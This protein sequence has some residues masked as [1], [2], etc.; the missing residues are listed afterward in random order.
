MKFPNYELD[1]NE[2]IKIAQN[3]KVNELYLFGSILTKDFTSKSDIDILVSFSPES[4]VSLF[5]LQNL[6]SKLS[7]ILHRDVDLI[8][9]EGLKNPYRRKTILRSARKIYGH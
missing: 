5:E 6:K 4:A 3:F 9:I 7:N 8:E 1:E 2:I